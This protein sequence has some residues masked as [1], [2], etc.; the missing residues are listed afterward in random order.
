MSVLE[1]DRHL[2]AL[3]KQARSLIPKDEVIDM[4]L[5]IRNSKE[6]Q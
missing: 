6:D 3:T 4:L 1:I 2:S 5:D